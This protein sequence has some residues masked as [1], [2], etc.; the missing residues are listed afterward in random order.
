MENICSH[1]IKKYGM[2][3]WSGKKEPFCKP[4]MT[5]LYICQV[6]RQP[7]TTTPMNKTELFAFLYPGD[8]RVVG[9]MKLGL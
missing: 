4:F 8:L 5:L 6:R 7:P 2:P 1:M 3:I 9:T